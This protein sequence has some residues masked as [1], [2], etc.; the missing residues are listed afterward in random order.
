M[1][2][3]FR[4]SVERLTAALLLRLFPKLAAFEPGPMPVGLLPLEKNGAALLILRGR[5]APPDSPDTVVL[6]RSPTATGK[7][8]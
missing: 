3:L 6:Y 4:L 5:E 2:R 7:S 8:Q 1:K